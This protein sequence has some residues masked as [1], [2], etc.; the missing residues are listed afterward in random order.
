MSK[1]YAINRQNHINCKFSMIELCELKWERTIVKLKPNYWQNSSIGF[2]QIYKN[3]I[4]AW[5][6]VCYYPK[7]NTVWY[8]KVDLKSLSKNQFSDT[9]ISINQSNLNESTI[10]DILTNGIE[11]YTFRPISESLIK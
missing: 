1:Y 6:K 3:L 5:K 2:L 9:T 7:R 8:Y 10:S 4:E 11:R